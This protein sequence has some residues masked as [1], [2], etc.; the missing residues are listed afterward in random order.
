MVIRLVAVQPKRVGHCPPTDINSIIFPSCLPYRDVPRATIQAL[1]K[2]RPSQAQKARFA[3]FCCLAV[4]RTDH[5]SSKSH[6]LLDRRSLDRIV[7][8]A[9]RGVL[10]NAPLAGEERTHSGTGGCRSRRTSPQHD[11]EA[12]S[13]NSFPAQRRPLARRRAGH[14]APQLCRA[15]SRHLTRPANTVTRAVW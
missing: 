6:R 4:C 15:S 1:F 3:H 12:K 14:P 9:H 11:S 5:S 7:G 10:L 8:G 2:S 13:E